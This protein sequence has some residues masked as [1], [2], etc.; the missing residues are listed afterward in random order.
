MA[1]L[2]LPQGIA[3]DSKGNLYVADYGN[4]RVR[5]V[6]LSTGIITTIAGAGDYHFSGDGAAAVAAGVDPFDV[7][8]DSAG[9]VYI[10]DNFN[11]RVR[12]VTGSTGNI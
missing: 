11:N 3:L 7:A 6:V 1:E 2:N 12:K 9:N 4:E 5:K 8:A 10:A